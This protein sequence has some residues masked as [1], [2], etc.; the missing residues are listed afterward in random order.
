MLPRFAPRRDGVGRGV[1]GAEDDVRD[2]FDAGDGLAARD[3][4]DDVVEGR[5]IPRL[6]WWRVGRERSGFWCCF[7][8]LL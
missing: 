5:R 4:V 3:Q 7:G 6:R 2:G 1:L 8:W